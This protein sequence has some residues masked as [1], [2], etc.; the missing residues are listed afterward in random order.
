M[1]KENKKQMIGRRNSRYLRQEEG[2]YDIQVTFYCR[3]ERNSHCGVH[4]AV[5]VG[6]AKLTVIVPLEKKLFFHFKRNYNP[7]MY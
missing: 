2:N 1:K 5:E 6:T 4:K 3:V 7:L